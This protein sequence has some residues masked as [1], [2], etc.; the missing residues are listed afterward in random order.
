MPGHRLFARLY[1]LLG[2]AAERGWLGDR[3][4][5]LLAP[6]RGRVVE[7]GAGTGANLRHYPAL[8]TELTLTEPDPAMRRRL[9]R[10]V[11]ARRGPARVVAAPAERLPL[12]DASADVVVA[13][14]VLCS[15]ADQAA[16][17]AEARRVLRPGGTLLFME[18][19]RGEGRRARVQDAVAPVWR[20]LAAGC[21]P[22]R[23]TVAAIRAA[24]FEVD[25]LEVRD[26][27]PGPPIVRPV[28]IGAAV[29]P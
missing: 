17:L 20:R 4:R 19:V 11:S 8:V 22:D 9:L 21:N 29:R 15:V 18:H 23:D 24:G 14:L 27:A 25:R 13:T 5:E 2:A 1:D 16:A 10:R 3:R 6:A 7:V 12:P 28:A 26:D